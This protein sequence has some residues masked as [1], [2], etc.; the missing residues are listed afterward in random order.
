M[1]RH[2]RQLDG[3]PEHLLGL[4]EI[5]SLGEDSPEAQRR[6]RLD[7]GKQEPA[8][9]LEHSADGRLSESRCSFEEEQHEGRLESRVERLLRVARDQADLICEPTDGVGVGRKDRS[10]H[11]S[12]KRGEIRAALRVVEPVRAT[13][14]LD[15]VPPSRGSAAAGPLGFLRAVLEPAQDL[16]LTRV[17]LD[18]E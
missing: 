6:L 15:Q 17:G 14:L 13:C 5:P 12:A 7:G 1:P 10:V 8:R 2:A 4:L 16:R 9:L 11:L 18:L 3:L